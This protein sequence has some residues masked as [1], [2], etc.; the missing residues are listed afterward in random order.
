[1]EIRDSEQEQPKK[2][3][4][5][6]FNF[7]FS[8]QDIVSW[9]INNPLDTFLILLIL[10]GVVLAINPFPSVTGVDRII[11]LLPASIRVKALSSVRWVAYGGG[12]QISGSVFFVIGGGIG[13]LRLRQHLFKMRSLR[14]VVCPNCKQESTLKRIHRTKKDRLINLIGIP[15]KRYFCKNCKWKGLRLDENLV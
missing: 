11:Q 4:K 8:R 3:R 14:N 13:L 7:K 5:K 2:K 15:T 9:L 12:A 10:V 6:R 1:M